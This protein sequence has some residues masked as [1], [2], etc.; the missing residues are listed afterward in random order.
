MKVALN[1]LT[2]SSKLELMSRKDALI[3]E[4][5][6]ANPEAIFGLPLDWMKTRPAEL[7]EELSP[8]RRNAPPPG[9]AKP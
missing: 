8:V 3:K 6:S 1:K 9:A 7:M 2:L 5:E 4:I